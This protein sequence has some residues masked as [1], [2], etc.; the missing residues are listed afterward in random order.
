MFPDVLVEVRLPDGTPSVRPCIHPRQALGPVGD[1]VGDREGRRL[2][3]VLHQEAPDQ[4]VDLRVGLR[5]GQPSV[6]TIQYPRRECDPAADARLE[7]TVTR[8]RRT[9]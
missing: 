3:H 2:L 7:H 8:G 4:P 9:S 1:E 5:Q 6:E